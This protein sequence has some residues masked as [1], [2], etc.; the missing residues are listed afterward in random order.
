MCCESLSA[1]STANF[2]SICKSEDVTK[3]F[4]V[5][6]FIAVSVPDVN[7]MITY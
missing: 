7:P 6:T 2:N 4:V 1:V 3:V 5:S